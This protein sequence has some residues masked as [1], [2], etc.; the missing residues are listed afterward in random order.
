MI[1]KPPSVIVNEIALYWSLEM[2]FI[3]P[4]C[5]FW[6]ISLWALHTC[7]SPNLNQAVLFTSPVSLFQPRLL[8]PF[9]VIAGVLED[10][11]Y[12]VEINDTWIYINWLSQSSLF[13]ETSMSIYFLNIF[14][15]LIVIFFSFKVTLSI[16]YGVKIKFKILEAHRFLFKTLFYLLFFFFF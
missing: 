5:N 7:C 6:I 13:S 14:Y 8:L 10:L 2:L 9:K 12:Q 11:P 1:S 15:L 4:N 3:P 16:I